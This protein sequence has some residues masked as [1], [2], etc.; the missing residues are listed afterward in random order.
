MQEVT[1]RNSLKEKEEAMEL[2]ESSR[3]A[4]W[5]LP[6]FVAE[7]FAGRFRFD[8]I[9]PYLA[10]DPKDKAE[11]DAFL[12]KFQTFLNEKLDA[13]KI[14][15]E[16]K[17]PAE[18]IQGLVQ[19]GAFGMKIPKEYGG[20]GFSQTN[21]NRALEM[22]GGHCGST[23][24]W[25]SAHQSIGAPQPLKM[26]GT[27][28]QK[29]KFLPRLTREVSAFALT[30][31]EVGSD[32]A[33][34]K[35][36]AVPSPDGRHWILN[37]EKLWCTNGSAADILI[38]MARTPD[39]MV[40]GK[41]RK[42]IS[43]F[44]VERTMPGF[45]VKRRC[46]FMGI[47]A[48]ENGLLEF[49]N[50]MVPKENLV[51]E[52]GGGLK[53]A[54]TTLNTGRLSLPS[55]TI[56]LAK[57]CLEILRH[58]TRERVQWGFPIGQHEE[59][60]Q[61]T[62]LVATSAFAM[63]AMTYWICQLVD[64]G[65]ADIRLEAA[66]A[67]L[68]CTELSYKTTYETLQVRGGRGFETAQSLKARGE[69][70]VPIERC[71]RDIRVN[72]ILEG[73]S[74]I[75]HLF[76]A[77]EALDLHMRLASDL[78][79]PRTPISKKITAFFKVGGFYATWYPRQ[80][81]YWGWFPKYSHMGRLACHLRFI[82]RSSRR[83]AR[84]IFHLMMWYR[85]GL[86][87]KQLI[88]GRIV[89][90]GT[91]LFAMAAACSKAKTLS[92]QTPERADAVELADIFCREA[93]GKIKQYFK[94]IWSNHDQAHLSIS[95]QVMNDTFQWLEE[96]TLK[97]NIDFDHAPR[98]SQESQV[99][100]LGRKQTAGPTRAANFTAKVKASPTEPSE[101]SAQFS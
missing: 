11:G 18:I 94:D 60:A 56:G 23:A 87:K 43:A 9:Y 101:F 14:D 57:K 81:I 59:I 22:V 76:I 27:S 30:E 66:M 19:L 5:K 52:V 74:E 17:M 28:E 39:I 68:F 84:T 12:D 98:A 85:L 26:F 8:L 90:I 97:G 62:S 16:G 54:L 64:H 63:E 47:R 42:Q 3:E 44:L 75:M 1:P 25:L 73:S 34:M 69:V 4:E 41:P 99:D 96:G 45:R 15:E 61:K 13:D 82:D 29:K 35:T 37:G 38:V 32:P 70:P 78:L 10:Q 46:Q 72:T 58:W 2:A 53:L 7:L 24:A 77:R 91:L 95:K 20:L 92:D 33:Q 48:I 88:L 65:K 51:G 71:L 21:Y 36:T 83:L 67:K 31:P 55:I 50:V 40:H 80:W 79:N 93:R 89:E 100:S 6:S 49:N 86:E